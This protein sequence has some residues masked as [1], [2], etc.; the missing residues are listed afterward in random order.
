ML[1]ECHRILFREVLKFHSSWLEPVLKQSEKDYLVVPVC[2]AMSEVEPCEVFPYL[3]MDIAR[4]VAGNPRMNDVKIEW[5][6][7]LEWFDDALVID[8]HRHPQERRLYQVQGVDKHTT[9]LS[10]F[11]DQS[12][13]DTF[14]EYFSSK[15]NFTL[16]DPTQ[17]GLK[18]VVV[19]MSESR[20]RLL[21]SRFK[22]FQ[23]KD[24]SS[25]QRS[26]PV[27]L[28][29]E[30]CSLY[31][32]P[33]S[34][35]KIV[36]CL[37]TILWRVESILL[38][39]AFRATLARE[40]QIGSS[41]NGL[42]RMTH[43]KLRGYKDS[44]FGHL[45]TQCFHTHDDASEATSIDLP[46][47]S[48]ST[49]EFPLRG[50]D[51]A[52]FLQ[53]LTLKGADDSINLERLETLGDSFLKVATAV[54]LYCQLPSAHEGRLSQKRMR[55]VGNFNLYVL[56]KQKNLPGQILAKSFKP[57]EMWIPPCF[58]FNDRDPNIPPT[59]AHNTPS[60]PHVCR[61]SEVQRH[62]QFQKISDKGVA[63]CVEALLGAYLVSGGIEAGVRF[64]KWMGIKI[65]Q[66]VRE[67]GTQSVVEIR[68]DSSSSSYSASPVCKR[69]KGSSTSSSSSGSSMVSLGCNSPL[70]IRDS[71]SVFTNHFGLPPP[72]LLVPGSE[73]EVLRLLKISR[74]SLKP[75]QIQSEI[76]WTFSDP[77]LLL[78]ALTHASFIKNRVTDCYQ[79]LEFL[80]DAVLDYLVTCH[81]YSTFPN[82]EPGQI[83]A[84]RSA[85]VN[86]V[87]FAEMAVRLNL[88]KA[89]LH[90][91][92]ILFRQIPEYEESLKCSGVQNAA[93][94][95]ASTPQGYC[96]EVSWKTP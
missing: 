76:D 51:N 2:L 66:K 67:S 5:P 72:S 56:A 19:S 29:P 83:S 26:S 95:T 89:L 85:L 68:P 3:D 57:W 82:Y 21:T 64:M 9:P 43:T 34:F 71:S 4:T 77:A 16:N 53:A 8:I 74:S 41:L 1:V 80:G 20:L 90:N 33:A 84:L 39:D 35:W 92:L 60:D 70:Y 36:R 44:G 88:H 13:A 17:P 40:T 30:C 38:V 94:S 59:S 22:G 91:S 79:R 6:C 15:Y 37:P 49:S 75:E 73:S 81:I 27:I 31:P 78:Q 93:A 28:F 7:P 32:L 42:E 58:K 47:L 55:R 18:C 61:L 50:P 10:S 65:G 11:P 96:S 63:D 86:N 14:L 62:Y 54:H 46:M 87:T 23:G 52:L 24:N 25:G 48:H 12:Q 45:E 69:M